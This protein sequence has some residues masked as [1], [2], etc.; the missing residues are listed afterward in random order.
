MFL[1]IYGEK[2]FSKLSCFF[3]KLFFLEYLKCSISLQFTK[4]HKKLTSKRYSI[5]YNEM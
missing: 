1:D 4:F 3:K 5:I 2:K